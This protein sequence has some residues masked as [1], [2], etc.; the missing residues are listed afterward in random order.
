MLHRCDLIT[1]EFSS[2]LKN[3]YTSLF[4]NSSISKITTV[5]LSLPPP[6]SPVT[7]A[8]YQLVLL[9]SHGRSSHKPSPFSSNPLAFFWLFSLSTSCPPPTIPLWLVS[10]T[11]SP[12]DLWSHPACWL[13]PLS[14]TVICFLWSW[15]TEQGWAIFFRIQ[16]DSEYFRL[17]RS[18]TDSVTHS[19]LFLYLFAWFS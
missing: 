4:W 19:S 15:A 12:L 3:G 5:L 10:L 14:H 18:Q 8:S 16:P 6:F 2:F 1:G 9:H 13:P 17:W 11:L 7:F